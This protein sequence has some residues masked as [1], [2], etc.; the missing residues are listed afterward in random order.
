MYRIAGA[1]AEIRHTRGRANKLGVAGDY[2]NMGYE[3]RE[4]LKKIG[5]ARDSNELRAWIN[6]LE[7]NTRA[8]LKQHWRCVEKVAAE[9]L[10]KHKLSGKYVRE[11]MHR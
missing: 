3:L 1:L 4:T 11:L 2:E 9:L 5:E 7:S 8:L 6:R 10:V